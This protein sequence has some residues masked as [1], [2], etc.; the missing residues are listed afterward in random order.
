LAADIIFGIESAG[1]SAAFDKETGIL[2]MNAKFTAFITIVRCTRTR[3]NYPLWQIDFDRCPR[4]DL[5]VVA[6]MD[7]TAES[8]IDYY[9]FPRAE[10]SEG[11]RRLC[12]KNGIHAETYRFCT[13][14]A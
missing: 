12:D 11:V 1:G 10:V 7:E 3:A 13:L 9:V 2:T 14:D 4:C 8:I 6:R 5:T